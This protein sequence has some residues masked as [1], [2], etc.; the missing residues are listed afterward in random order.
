[1]NIEVKTTKKQMKLNIFCQI[2]LFL[3]KIDHIQMTIA[4]SYF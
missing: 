4:L 3:S 1:M 2:R